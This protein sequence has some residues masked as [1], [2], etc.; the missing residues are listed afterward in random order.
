MLL[1][2]FQIIAESVPNLRSLSLSDNK[3]FST[4]HFSMLKK[5]ASELKSLNLSKNKVSQISNLLLCINFCNEALLILKII[6]S[7]I[8]DLNKLDCL[9]GLKL[10]SLVLDDNP[11]C[12]KFTDQTSY[13][14]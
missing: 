9:R 11:L 14:R 2:V 4:E 5:H 8:S 10:E 7:Q 3:I 1:G 12:D 6:S 13:V